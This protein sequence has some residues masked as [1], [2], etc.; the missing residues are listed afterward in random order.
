MKEKQSLCKL[1]GVIES[2]QAA[3][4]C[5]SNSQNLQKNK[6]G[7]KNNLLAY[8]SVLFTASLTLNFSSSLWLSKGPQAYVPNLNPGSTMH[9]RYINLAT[10][11]PVCLKLAVSWRC[12]FKNV[13][14]LI[15]VLLIWKGARHD[16][17][18]ASDGPETTRQTPAFHPLSHFLKMLDGRLPPPLPPPSSF[19]PFLFLS[20]HA[21]LFFLFRHFHFLFSPSSPLTPLPFF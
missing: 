3:H 12:S 4:K 11:L 15:H 21:S 17:L 13:W 6:Q 16:P 1:E 10:T 5:R 9:A 14:R 8:S 18:Y 7:S 19:L 20:L 2:R